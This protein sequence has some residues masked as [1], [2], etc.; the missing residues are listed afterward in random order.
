MLNPFSM[1]LA[2][3]ITMLTFDTIKTFVFL[4]RIKLLKLIFLSG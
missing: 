2:G 3:F 1:P 4:R